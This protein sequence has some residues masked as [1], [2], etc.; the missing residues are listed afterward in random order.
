MYAEK[1]SC[2]SKVICTS[3]KAGTEDKHQSAQSVT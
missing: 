2:L 3:A 1:A